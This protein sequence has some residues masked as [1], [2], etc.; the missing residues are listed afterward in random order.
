MGIRLGIGGL[1]IG[2]GSTGINWSSYWAT[3][4]ALKYDVL[5]GLDLLESFSGSNLNAKVLP[6]TYIG[7][8][9]GYYYIGAQNL[10]KSHTIKVNMVVSGAYAFSHSS[11]TGGTGSWLTLVENSIGYRVG[12]STR[13]IPVTMSTGYHEIVLV[14]NERLINITIDGVAQTQFDLTDTYNLDWYLTNIGKVAA[15]YTNNV[16]SYVAFNDHEYVL[17]GELV[18]YDI[19]TN[20]TKLNIGLTTGSA[21]NKTYSIYGS[22]L[23][24]TR[25]VSIYNK[26]VRIANL[27]VPYSSTGAATITPPTDYLKIRDNPAVAG[28]LI[29]V[30]ALIDFDYSDVG[31]AIKISLKRD[32]T[33][34]FEDVARTGYYDA[35]NAYRWHI[36]EL[37]RE[38]L[39]SY[40]KT[41]YKWMVFPHWEANS[42]ETRGNIDEL[43]ITSADQSPTSRN[44]ALSYTGDYGWVTLTDAGEAY[45]M[46]NEDF[47]YRVISDSIVGQQDDYILKQDGTTLYLSIN[48]GSTYPY[49]KTITGLEFIQFFYAWANGNISFADRGKMYLTTDNFST[50]TEVI[51]KD[52][53]GDD[54]AALPGENYW[55]MIVSRPVFIG[56]NEIKVFTNYGNFFPSVGRYNETNI[57]YSVDNGVSWK[58][59]YLFGEYTWGGF[60]SGDAGNAQSVRH[61]HGVGFNPAD[62]SFWFH[63]GDGTDE[64]IIMRG[65]YNSGTDTWTWTKTYGDN[66]GGSDTYA[67]GTWY[68]IVGTRFLN[69]YIYWGGDSA[70]PARKGVFRCLVSNFANTANYV[71]LGGSGGQYIDLYNVGLDFIG[72]EMKSSSPIT[73]IIVTSKD[74]EV[75]NTRQLNIGLSGDKVLLTL[76]GKTSDGWFTA[77]IQEY[78]YSVANMRSGS[79]LFIKLK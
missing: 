10:G 39:T 74:A 24:I 18:V 33:T 42:V 9:T 22:T 1:K 64:C 4:L 14:R 21:A 53:N 70:T 54:F 67:N 25:G 3:R 44:A 32:D 15:L 23:P 2:Q 37:N 28:R 8:G 12:G 65:T 47:Y 17:N 63:S 72:S 16:I 46:E 60:T 41:N 76:K 38:L 11:A 19:G 55:E 31:E 59:S 71:K 69:D 40:Y 30:D 68:K 43:L 51:P 48:G 56:G 73:R 45:L 57:W 13:N 26:V 7:A 27:Y 52:V 6:V 77:D 61:G 49:S 36:S 62:N 79:T 50:V 35:A 5:S 29:D 20:A 58:S 75:F 78:P 66:D 34:V